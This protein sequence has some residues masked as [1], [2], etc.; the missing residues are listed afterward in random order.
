MLPQ[1]NA[2]LTISRRCVGYTQ[3]INLIDGIKAGELPRP[4]GIFHLASTQ[5]AY[6]LLADA[7]AF[8][9]RQDQVQI[10]GL[11]PIL[12]TVPPAC[13]ASFAG[14]LVIARYASGLS[15]RLKLRVSRSPGYILDVPPPKKE[16][17][18]PGIHNH[19]ALMVTKRINPRTVCGG[20]PSLGKK[21]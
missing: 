7:S 19:A 16:Q 14:S 13:H 17:L 10:L 8:I 1:N 9:L 15:L 4:R 11:P 12:L 18:P 5:N 2:S 20:L 3:L 21:R 6:L